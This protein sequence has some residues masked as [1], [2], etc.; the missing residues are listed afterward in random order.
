MC[1]AALLLWAHSFII[2]T[3][4]GGIDLLIIMKCPLPLGN[5][6]KSVLSDVNLP[7]PALSVVT[8]CMC[9]F[10]SF[11]FQPGGTFDLEVDRF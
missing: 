3:S 1:F 5:S 7:A 2:V 11:Y 10:P 8:V 9:I 4:S 6:L